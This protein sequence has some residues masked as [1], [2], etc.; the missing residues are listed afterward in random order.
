MERL[1]ERTEEGQAIPRMELRHNG[2]Q[3]CMDRLAE[4]EDIGTVEECREAREKQ[5]AK[6]P[7]YEGDGYSD[8]EMV[9]DTWICPNCGE[10]Y[11]VGFDD[12]SY[13]PNCGQHLDRL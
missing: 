8:G 6:M 3:R 9:Y 11:E 13:C 5:K 12:Y 1:T 7:T 4:Y 2:H 10:Y